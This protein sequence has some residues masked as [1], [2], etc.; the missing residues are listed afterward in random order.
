MKVISEPT[1][2]DWD[3]GNLE[4]NRLSHQ[5][6][7]N[8]CEETFLD[9]SKVIFKDHMHSNG[10]ERFRI[11]GKTRE[12]RLLFIVFTKRERK[13][14]IISARDINKK[15]VHLYEKET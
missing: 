11:L 1:E 15:E 2:F 13:I 3:E 10:E 5:V 9:P 6:A 7:S 12:G 14:R 8:E 4:K